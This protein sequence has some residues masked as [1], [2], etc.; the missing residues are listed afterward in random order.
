MANV[1]VI[2]P[3]T[4]N[5]F[6][7]L[8]RF[9]FD[10]ICFI[11]Q[12]GCFICADRHHRR[13]RHLLHVRRHR[14]G[15]C[16]RRPCCGR[17]CCYWLARSFHC[18]HRQIRHP[19]KPKGVRMRCDYRPGSWRYRQTVAWMACLQSF[20]LRV[21]FQLHRQGERHHMASQIDR[22]ARLPDPLHRR[23]TDGP[24]AFPWPSS[25]LLH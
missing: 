9:V 6:D 17:P 22:F 24:G 16:R 13:G 8:I 11:S 2:T 7:K 25:Q 10:F 19:E 14:H 15:S 18:R 1:Q 20:L 4:T 12:E 5:N 3:V 23:E 21:E